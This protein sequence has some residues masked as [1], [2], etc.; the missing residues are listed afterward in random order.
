MHFHA[1]VAVKALPADA[2]RRILQIQDAESCGQSN[3]RFELNH[4]TSQGSIK[5]NLY[6]LAA[7]I[8]GSRLQRF[9]ETSDTGIIGV[10]H[11]EDFIIGFTLSSNFHI[12]SIRT[13][14]FVNRVQ[15]IGSPVV[16]GKVNHL[17]LGQLSKHNLGVAEIIACNLHLCIQGDGERSNVRFTGNTCGGA[18]LNL[19]LR[20]SHP[21][22]LSRSAVLDNEGRGRD[23]AAL[24]SNKRTSALHSESVGTE[25]DIGRRK[26]HRGTACNRHCTGAESRTGCDFQ[27]TGIDGGAARVCIGGICQFQSTLTGL[28]EFVVAMPPGAQEGVDDEGGAGI[29]HEGGVI[30]AEAEAC[31]ID[32][33]LC[34]AALH[35]VDV[36]GRSIGKQI[37]IRTI[38]TGD[39]AAVH[40]DDR[41]TQGLILTV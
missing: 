30:L 2:H 16:A 17:T 32:E 39:G 18:R 25:V 12:G 4:L 14:S 28:D 6:R 34:R 35:R 9:T 36:H 7:C 31:Q 5:L 13:K 15:V 11:S 24:R 10:P 27:H 21:I 8:G 37:D 19:H 20:S 1:G 29:H 26:Q 3:F 38:H 22:Q 33:R 23:R 40:V 41:A